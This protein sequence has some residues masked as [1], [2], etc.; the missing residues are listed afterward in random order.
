MTQIIILP[1]L[2]ML[3]LVITARVLMK[4]ARHIILILRR[5]KIKSNTRMLLRHLLNLTRTRQNPTFL[6]IQ[7]K[8]PKHLPINPTTLTLS[9]KR[10]KKS[11]MILKASSM[12]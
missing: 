4:R 1:A 12:S 3:L 8:R 10:R 6:G 11:R 7:R 2:I 5:V 9:L